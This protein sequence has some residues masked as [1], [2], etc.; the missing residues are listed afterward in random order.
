MRE[1]KKNNKGFTLV[2]VLGTIVILGVVLGISVP[3]I[4]RAVKKSQ[5]EQM[6]TQEN[7]VSLVGKNYFLDN[8]DELPK[9]NGATTQVAVSDLVLEG[10][11]NEVKDYNNNVC[12][13]VNSYVEVTKIDKGDY[14]Y[15]TYLYCDGYETGDAWTEWAYAS[16][17][18]DLPGYPPVEAVVITTYNYYITTGSTELGDPEGEQ[19]TPY[20]PEEGYEYDSE[21]RYNYQDLQENWSDYSAYTSWATTTPASLP[22][23]TSTEHYIY[24]Y[25][26]DPFLGWKWYGYGRRCQADYTITKNFSTYDPDA[27]YFGYEPYPSC[28]DTYSYGGYIWYNYVTI[29]HWISG[30]YYWT[31][32]GFGRSPTQITFQAVCSTLGSEWYQISSWREYASGYYMSAPYN[33]PYKESTLYDYGTTVYT[34]QTQPTG[35]YDINYWRHMISTMTTSY[36]ADVL[37][38]YVDQGELESIL[39][40]TLANLELDTN[41]S[42][43]SQD[44]YW[45]IPIIDTTV[46]TVQFAEDTYYS[47]EEFVDQFNATTSYTITSPTEVNDIENYTLIVEEVVKYRQR[48][49]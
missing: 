7:N 15:S 34:G 12:D 19:T 49:Y 5:L 28:P 41:Y 3:L 36:S 43:Q 17:L 18:P 1:E 30:D 6:E 14:D 37:P 32:C 16:E 10:Y 8:R 25:K 21:T 42:I 38:E 35:T 26:Y 29:S 44:Y 45:R 46:D 33:Y 22:S 13:L 4:S 23:N 11:I 2:E 24:D 31:S 27:Y 48:K 47:S 9:I 40:D 39:E 20:T